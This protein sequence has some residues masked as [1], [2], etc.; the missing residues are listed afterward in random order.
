VLSVWISPSLNAV[1]VLLQ[2]RTVHPCVVLLLVSVIAVSAQPFQPGQNMAPL[3][4]CNVVDLRRARVCTQRF[5]LYSLQPLYSCPPSRRLLFA[6]VMLTTSKPQVPHRCQNVLVTAGNLRTS[7][8][9]GPYNLSLLSV[10]EAEVKSG[11]AARQNFSDAD[12][13]NFLTNVE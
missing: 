7:D 3:G 12:I 5:P 2:M 11:I 13:V 4:K 1:A 6:L 10:Q 8:F 9:G